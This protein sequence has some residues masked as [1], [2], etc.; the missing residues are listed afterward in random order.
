M[1][2]M[3]RRFCSSQ[4]R[5]H[6]FAERALTFWKG[7]SVPTLPQINKRLAIT[8]K[9]EPQRID[10]ASPHDLHIRRSYDLTITII[11]APAAAIAQ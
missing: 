6:V 5:I 2:R 3:G 9:M 4:R 10:Y 7:S 8:R 11:V 1:H